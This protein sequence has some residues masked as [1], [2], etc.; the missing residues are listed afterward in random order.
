MSVDSVDWV[1]P[2]RNGAN[3]RPPLIVRPVH[4][5]I[6][7]AAW[8]HEHRDRVTGWLHRAGAVLLR[9]FGVG[10]SDFGAVV[11]GLSGE[12]LPYLERS[13]PRTEVGDR[14]YTATDH[15]ADQ[16]IALHNENSYQA[17]FPG[18]LVFCCVRPP[19]SGGA[20]PVADTRAI[21]SRLDPAVVDRFARGGV[22]YVRNYAAGLGV[23]WSEAFGT[24]DPAAVRDYCAAHDI[25]LA[26]L[27]GDRLR[28]SQV[29][30]ALARH[31]VTGERVWFNHAA[32]FHVL[33]LP[34][35]LRETLLDQLPES[36][37]PNNSYYGDGSPIEPEVLAHL[38]AAYD[39][40]RSVV[41][42][43]AGDVLLVDNLLAAHGREPFTGPRRVLVGMAGALRWSRVRDSEVRP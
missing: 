24:D 17:R 5:G 20:T 7:L 23:S 16:R 15:P 32:F 38:S 35:A 36:D 4:D 10:G 39:A 3:P 1:R 9:G 8:A 29:R 19:A 28:T 18:A 13:T 41:D 31:P 42:W 6:D 25:D 14:I 27:P 22:C 12:P 34:A 21:L 40:E 26:W 43:Q 30:P 2:D 11:R 37:L 33:S